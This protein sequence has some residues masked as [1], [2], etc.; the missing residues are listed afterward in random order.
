[1]IPTF[2]ELGAEGDFSAQAEYLFSIDDRAYYCVTDMKV[3][4]F[5]GFY[6]EPLTVFRNFE[7]LHQAFAGITGSQLYRWMQSRRFCGG[8]GA[9]TEPSL[10]ERALVCPSCG[11]TEYPKISPAV[12]VAITNGDKLLM[13]R[14]ARGAYR[15]YALIAGFVEIGETFEDCVRREVME[16]VGLRVKNIRYYKRPA[17]GIFRLRRWWDLRQSWTGM[18][19]YVW[20]KRSCARPAGLH[21]MKSWN[22]DLI[23]AW[24][25]R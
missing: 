20:R 17:L 9:K 5:G 15:N 4:E 12:I 16:E 2:G 3:P 8:C 1:M 19:P 6:M 11:Q 18:T 10:K 13:S 22:T 24:D 7:P 21:G 23:S 14:Y 25:M